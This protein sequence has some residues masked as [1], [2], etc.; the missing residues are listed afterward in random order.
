[1]AEIIAKP[2]IVVKSEKEVRIRIPEES[3]TLGN[4]ITKIASR[5]KGVTALYLV[6][7]PLRQV[8]WITIKTDGS[9]DAYKV[10]ME[11]ID[12]AIEYLERFVKELE[13]AGK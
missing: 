13:E 1:M 8:L 6:E 3:H 11:A 9:V 2:E 12:E 5:K 4:L 10:L 7:H